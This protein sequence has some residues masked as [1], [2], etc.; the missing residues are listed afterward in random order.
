V[1][2]I[3]FSLWA[4]LVTKKLCRCGNDAMK[5]V[6]YKFVCSTKS[7]IESDKVLNNSSG[8]SS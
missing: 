2:D 3:I 1:F 4:N 8:I 6:T 7:T 5:V